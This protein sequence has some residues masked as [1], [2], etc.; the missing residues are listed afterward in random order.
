MTGAGAAFLTGAGAAFL[1]GAGAAFLAGA[2]GAGATFLI[3]LLF[4]VVAIILIDDDLVA[5][6]INAA[7]QA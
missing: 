3:N 7:T 1:T 2:A 4:G 5:G 6:A